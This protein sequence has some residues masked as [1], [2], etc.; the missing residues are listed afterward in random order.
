[1]LALTVLALTL[2]AL[3]FGAPLALRRWQVRRLGRYCAAHRVII[4]TYDDGPSPETTT[5]LAD[6]LARRGAVASFFMIG[7]R[8]ATHPG[9][10]ARLLSEGHEVGN[11]TQSHLNA[12]KASPWASVRDL[13][14]G[15]RTLTHLGVPAGP[16]R[17]PYGKTTLATLLALWMDRCPTAF[18]TIDT[19]DSWER[20]RSIS[21]VLAMIEHQG[22]GV[23]LMHD[24]AFP[25]RRAA[26]L[27]HPENV[28]K[29]TEAIL[30]FAAAHNFRVL[31]FGDMAMSG[32]QGESV[33]SGRRR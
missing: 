32:L 9:L 24:F 31:R 18:W 27:R 6:L 20:P 5:V 26:D 11:H 13:R 4:L 15:Q 12:W 33:E 10:V 22:G 25:P 23:V 14:A 21:E 3:W 28:L 29:M 19:H 8:A 1:M 2:P 7:A 16:F 17:P 30:D